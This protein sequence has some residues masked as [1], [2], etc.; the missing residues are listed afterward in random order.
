MKHEESDNELEFFMSNIKVNGKVFELADYENEKEIESALDKLSEDIFGKGRIYINVKKLIGKENKGI[1]DGYLLDLSSKKPELYFIEVELDTHH[2]IKHIATQIL[3]FSLAFD[4]DKNRVSEIL[5]ESIE[6]DEK[7]KQKC[8]EYASNSYYENLHNLVFKTVNESKFQAAIV[9]NDSD[10]ILEKILNDKFQFDT[11]IINLKKFESVDGEKVY[12]YET[13]DEETYDVVQTN[14]SEANTI[15]DKS[16]F[17]TIVV[18]ARKEGFEETFIRENRWYKIKFSKKMQ[19]LIKYIA[20][21]QIR[22]ISQITH[23]AEIESI[24]QWED[25]NKYVVNFKSPAKK[26][27]Q[28][29]KYLPNGKTK[30][31]QCARFAEYSKLIK[32]ETF[33]DL[34]YHEA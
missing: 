34:W 15:I 21:Y 3:N 17:D 4:Q 1:P 11:F 16:K 28:P 2:V 20:A 30:S 12:Q 13:F 22:P 26:L 32:A 14:K 33:D 29:I 24:K 8:L 23:I 6:K 18:P 31:L 25:T 9:I 7:I 27:E 5:I 19:P 10:A